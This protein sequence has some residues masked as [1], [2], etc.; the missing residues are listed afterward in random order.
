M[1]FISKVVAVFLLCA[2]FVMGACY[3]YS[4]SY[5]KADYSLVVKNLDYSNYSL[6]NTR[7]RVVVMN[8]WATWCP[9]CIEEMPSFQ[10]LYDKFKDD[11]DFVFLFV[12][13]DDTR[14]R[15]L[16]FMKEGD[17]DFPVYLGDKFPD[18]YDSE[19]I[20]VTFIISKDGKIVK[21][22]EGGPDVWDR[23]EIVVLLKNL[24]KSVRYVHY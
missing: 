15:I 23:D 9:P 21:K 18:V 5:Q 14:D 13:V 6:E 17:Y 16:A 7:G 1:G 22:D 12:A 3:F 10:R 11:K 2:S 20:P 24:S 8:V 19:G 4:D